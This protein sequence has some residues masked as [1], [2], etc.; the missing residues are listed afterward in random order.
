MFDLF[1]SR[2]KIVR[3]LLGGVLLV[4]ALSMVITLIPGFGSSV[5][6]N[7]DDQIVAEI[8]KD[9]LTVSQVQRDIQDA[10]KSGRM[11]PALLPVFVPQLING[12]IQQ[13]AVAYQAQR[14][15]VVVTNDD[16]IGAIQS[17]M[18]QFFKEGKL[19][20]KQAF[21]DVLAQQ[22]LTT[23][24]LLE[25]FRRQL[26][27]QRLEIIADEGVIVTPKEVEE[28][29][30]RSHTKAK[31]EYIRFDPANF[32]T[33]V[34]YTPDD[35]QKYFAANRPNYMV[36]AKISFQLLIV[37]EK[38]LA[39]NVTIPE[40]QLRQTYQKNLDRFRTPERVQARHIL[41]D[42][43]KDKSKEEVDKAKAKAEDL[44]KQLKAGADFAELAKKN[45]QDPGSASK[46]GDLGWVVHGQ[47]VPEFEQATF[48]LKPKEISNVIKTDYGFHR[49]EAAKY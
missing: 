47:M 36:P 2:A 31:I 26:Y 14:M 21:E 38:K 25:T 41:I 30:R 33:Q 18:P 45:S 42:A 11:Q 12:Q 17:T 23:T 5:G 27:I 35:L 28:S 48:A 46:G 29:Y 10:V 7:V 8:G 44:D 22:G 37:D 9:V 13:R 1:R 4:V 49:K 40:A 19:V 15:G 6:Q 24:D 34:K 16:V 32:R 43:G 20:D 39:E 3:Y